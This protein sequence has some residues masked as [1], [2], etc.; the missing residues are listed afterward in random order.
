MGK[1]FERHPFLGG[2]VRHGVRIIFTWNVV[3]LCILGTFIVLGIFSAIIGAAAGTAPGENTYDTIY[4]K[5]QNQFLSIPIQG[6]ILGSSSEKDN[7][8]TLFN[9]GAT[10]G[11]DV[12]DQLTAA[13]D[14]DT[15]KGVVL[16][17]NSPGGTIF[18]AH[19]I[20]DG[21]KYY[22]TKTQKPV[23]AHIEGEGASGAYWSAVSADKIYADYG[24]ETG[25][26]GVIMGPFQ[27]YDGII[28]QDNG[29]LGGGVVTQNGIETVTITAGK[30]KDIGSPY[31]RLTG[32]EIESLQ[33]SVD[34]EYSEF[35][36]YVSGQRHIPEDTIRNSIGAMIYEP[37]TALQLK[38]IDQIGS[39]Q[40]V[41]T[42]LAEA[43]HFPSDY[44][45]VQKKV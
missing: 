7:I 6:I 22:K 42:A 26:I 2:L 39:R 1:F 24:T 10:Y 43:G 11:Y 8:S 14:D 27:Y 9:E 30:S 40:E 19:A 25:S 31:R 17:V 32:Q 13:A 5:G 12:K 37:K 45:I 21:V 15:I 29:L 20:A 41:Y 38:L 4:G 16:E 44:T 36:A 18:G 3:I 34:N 35:V 23:Y 28:S 33:K